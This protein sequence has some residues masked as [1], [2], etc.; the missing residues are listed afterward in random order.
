MTFLRV[1]MAVDLQQNVLVGLDERV[2]R[3][4]EIQEQK[5]QT[6]CLTA[7]VLALDRRASLC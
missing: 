7:A 1:A 2:C 4:S 3:W 5:K 6:S